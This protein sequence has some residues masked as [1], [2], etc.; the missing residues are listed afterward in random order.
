MTKSTTKKGPASVEFRNVTKRYG[1]V[2]A[3][4]D[5]SFT[6]EPGTLVTLLGPS[7]CGKTTTLRLI[8]GLEI[9]TEGQIRIAGED[10]TN[11]SA[12]DRDVSMVFQSYALFPH[13]N[14]LDNVA[15][16]PTV[17]GQKKSDAY[18]L[19]RQKLALVGLKDYDL[20]L[21]S[22]L[23]GGQQQRVAVARA[24]TMEPQVLLFDE[25][26]SNLD[27]KLRRR[28][29]EDI[30][31]LQRDL[32]LTVAYVTHDQ[33]E[34]LAV[35][36]RVIVMSNARIAQMGA[37]RELYEAPASLFVADFMGDS[38]L[39]DATVERVSGDQALVKIGVTSLELPSR[40]TKPGPCK[41]SIRPESLSVTAS[42]P[43]G[44]AIP[45]TIRK[46]AYLGT[47]MEYTLAAEIGELFVVDRDVANP[48][49]VGSTAYLALARTGVSIV[50]ST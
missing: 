11:L 28:V 39:I 31:D 1:T 49:P 24:L 13:M 5:V 46:A 18:D 25:P 8:A 33:Q 16:G 14:V 41:V 40:G 29:R 36:D 20:R 35:S 50:P 3:V 6:I 22:E 30:R 26:L 15:Y 32:N 47:H 17:A 4:S 23:S 43:Q 34:A 48:K 42:V 45:G 38:N 19:A 10:V 7:G 21:P 9:A 2:A 27:A 37:P 44:P 12:A